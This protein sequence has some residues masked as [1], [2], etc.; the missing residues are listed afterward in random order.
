MSVRD[1]YDRHPITEAQILTAVARTRDGLAGL[2]PA[3]LFAHD[4]D[5]YGGL[6]AVD[7]L[8]EQ[9]AINGHDRVLDVCAGLGGPARYLAHQRGCTVTA[10]ELNAGRALGAARLTQRVGLD[11]RV[12]VVRADAT[13]LPFASHSFDV[14]ISQEALLHIPDKAAVL[15]GCA[16]VLRPGGRLCFTDWVAH[17]TLS[18]DEG[19]QLEAL[20][21][22][23]NIQSFAGYRA[24]LAEAG[25]ADVAVEDLSAAWGTLLQERLAMFRSLRASTIAQHGSERFAEWDAL[26][27]FFVDLVVSGKLGGGRFLGRRP[28]AS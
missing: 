25:F 8:A 28:A 12:T 23:A 7:A 18:V 20:F 14:C 17:P 5:H 13:A 27:T 1:F 19:Q 11:E 6:A 9:A 3:D 21:A 22:A 4:Q 24:L 15:R 16:D 10:L 2:R 26:Y